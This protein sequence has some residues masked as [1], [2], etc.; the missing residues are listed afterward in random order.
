[1]T[2]EE[3]RRLIKSQ[4]YLL[5]QKLETEIDSIIRQNP[6]ACLRGTTVFLS[7]FPN[8]EQQKIL[9]ANFAQSGWKLDNFKSSQQPHN[10]Y[11]NDMEYS[12]FIRPL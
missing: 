9:Q 8:E 10:G 6:A 7:E 12:C 4:Q 1:M 11:E 5:I 3:A 2:V